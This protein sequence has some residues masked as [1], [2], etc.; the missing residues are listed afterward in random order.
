MQLEHSYA[1]AG[2][3]LTLPPLHLWACGHSAPDRDIVSTSQ[4]KCF[5]VSLT[6]LRFLHRFCGFSRILAHRDQSFD[7]VASDAC[8]CCFQCFSSASHAIAALRPKQTL[9]RASRVAG[10]FLLCR[11]LVFSSMISPY[12]TRG[13]HIPQAFPSGRVCRGPL[14]SRNSL[15]Y[16]LDIFSDIP[17]VFMRFYFFYWASGT[18]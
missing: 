12:F 4:Y 13:R 16:L 3:S 9:P 6:F 1:G 11:S 8:C 14:H 10:Q 15:K 18:T 2:C 17:C 7:H 5:L